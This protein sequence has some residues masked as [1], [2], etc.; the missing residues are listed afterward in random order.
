MCVCLIQVESIWVQRK[1]RGCFFKEEMQTHYVQFCVEG[2]D[3]ACFY[4]TDQTLAVDLWCILCNTISGTL[5][6]RCERHSPP[7]SRDRS[8]NTAWL[9]WNGGGPC[10]TS[11]R[12]VRGP[13]Q[14]TVSHCL[15]SIF[16]PH[17]AHSENGWSCD[18]ACRCTLPQMHPSSFMNPGI[19]LLRCLRWR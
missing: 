5:E 12:S 15:S 17:Q 3:S 16:T 19:E 18:C 2:S 10:G 13:L 4:S 11:R 8:M 7:R 6:E 1:Q 14:V 9:S